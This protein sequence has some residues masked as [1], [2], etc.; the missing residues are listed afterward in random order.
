MLNGFSIFEI[1]NA[2]IP[3]IRLTFSSENKM[4]E[5][6]LE[7]KPAE[8]ETALRRTEVADSEHLLKCRA[9]N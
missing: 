1:R 6:A 7:E 4:L 3:K 5:E 2:K 8:L 9:D